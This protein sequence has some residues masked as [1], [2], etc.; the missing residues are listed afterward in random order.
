MPTR[1][2]AV[3][4]TVLLSAM[5]AERVS[6]HGDLHEQ[7]TRVSALIEKEPG[8]AELLLQRGELH[9]LHAEFPEAAADLE[10]ATAL[11]PGW[12]QVGIAKGRLAL[13]SGKFEAAVA[14]MDQ[15]LP[16]NPEYPEAWLI[17]ARARA[18]LADPIGAARDYTE[19]VRRLEKPEP[20]VF[21]ERAA[22]LIAAGDDHLPGALSG[23]EEGITKL[24]NLVTLDLA[25]LDLELKM[26]RFEQALQRIDRILNTSKRRDSWLARRG[27]VQVLFG[28]TEGARSSYNEALEAIAA[29]PMHHQ[30][31]AATAELKKRVTAA[32]VKLDARP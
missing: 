32:L 12:P 23:L 9:R 18:R 4:L 31:T 24:G 10:K 30:V 21:L 11:R 16:K 26:K 8:N 2:T 13:S 20:D 14:E 7:I 17:R 19:I 27:D 25:A 1:N 3:L 6:A 22:S 5:L 15:L 29:L 28:Q